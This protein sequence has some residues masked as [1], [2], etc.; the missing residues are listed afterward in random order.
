MFNVSRTSGV[1]DKDFYRKCYLCEEHLSSFEIDHFFP[2]SKFPGL[3]KSYNNHFLVCSSCNKIKG[4]AYNVSASTLLLNCCKDDV[5]TIV[6]LSYNQI[7]HRID[8]TSTIHSIKS[9]NQVELLQKIYNGL[10]STN[11]RHPFLRKD[12]LD[13]LVNLHKEI[14]R[15]LTKPVLRKQI[16]ASIADKITLSDK[17]E[18]QFIS[19]KKDLL[20]KHYPAIFAII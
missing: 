19:F 17:R 16:L 11:Q 5:E 13:C 8:I 1:L 9:I 15:Y 3:I 7:N 2:K 6:Q 4:A 12:I 18:S 20:K 10:C 14:G